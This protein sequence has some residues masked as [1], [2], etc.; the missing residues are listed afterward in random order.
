MCWVLRSTIKAMSARKCLP[1]LKEKIDVLRQR[2]RCQCKVNNALGELTDT[3]WT[4]VQGRDGRNR[5]NGLDSRT[6]ALDSYSQFGRKTF[7]KSHQ[8]SLDMTFTFQIS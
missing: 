6:I 1:E 5:G 7:L 8:Q 3:A 2:I 4:S